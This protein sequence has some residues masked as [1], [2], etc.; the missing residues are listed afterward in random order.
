MNMKCSTKKI[1]QAALIFAFSISACLA[2]PSEKTF[3]EKRPGMLDLIRKYQTTQTKVENLPGKERIVH[4]PKDRSIGY[5][6]SAN[7]PPVEDYWQWMQQ[8][9]SDVAGY[10]KYIGKAIGDVT[11]PTG[12]MLRLDVDRDAL[13]FE[14]P[15]GYLKPDDIQM[16]S[17]CHCDVNDSDLKDIRHLSGLEALNLLG[18]GTRTKGRLRGT[19]LKYLADLP[20][21]KYL[22]LPGY[23]S[24]QGLESLQ[25]CPSLRLLYFGGGVSFSDEKLRTVGKLTQ[26]THLNLGD[27]A[28][29]PGLVYLK[30]LRPL[31]YLN[32]AMN[33]HP[34]MDRHLT[35][36]ADL[37]EIEELYLGGPTMTDQAL[38]HLTKMT[39]LKKLHL[40]QS[41]V[42]GS[43]LP[44][45]VGLTQ[46]EEL[47][48]ENSQIGD[49][50]LVHIGKM[51]NLRK[52]NISSNPLTGK[53][54]D[55]G[56]AH[57]KDL[58]LLEDIV[59][60]W[61]GLTDAGLSNL[62]ALTAMKKMEVGG[63]K[64]TGRGI[65]VFANMKHLE[66]LGI[67]GGNI[68][69]AAMPA[70]AGCTS[71][72]EL[73]LNGCSITDK[74]FTHIAKLKSLEKLTITRTQITG[75][76]LAVLKDLPKLSELGLWNMKLGQTGLAHLAGCKALRQLTIYHLDIGLR[77]Q[78]FAH[79]SNLTSLQSLQANG[80]SSITNKALGSLS[81]LTLLESIYITGN[82][83]ITDDGLKYMA[84]LNSLRSIHLSKCPVTG[85]GLK[86][87]Q[88]L[89]SLQNLVLDNSSVTKTDTALLERAIPGL[90]CQV[91][92]PSA[93]PRPV[94]SKPPGPSVR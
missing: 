6:Y 5:L 19:G 13:K 84:N 3:T 2:A 71:L 54:T 43:G 67:V 74:G 82:S 40:S 93:M 24:M 50:G 79:L 16:L 38:V 23:V 15:F 17:F 94:I 92:N 46:M 45:L 28:I 41:N 85:A 33:R 18:F 10:I 78:D 72:K 60:P 86:H 4:F 48:M 49:T 12:R 58:K 36:I 47:D 89:S 91:R 56:L 52:L 53:V 7:I 81:G 29:G 37:T 21:L 62:A 66:N 22:F 55:A 59:L 73:S 39:Q 57:L 87:L 68:T 80:T 9:D 75:D 61:G 90:V 34:Q 76:G 69:D 1:L 44:N 25:Q 65:A 42:T 83:S 64:I 8:G 27:T 26:L 70:L 35:N 11:V 32:L 88:H 14:N 20:K 51:P 31:K 63:E 30:D 77:D